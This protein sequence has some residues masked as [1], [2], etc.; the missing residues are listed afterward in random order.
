MDYFELND[1]RYE[2]PPKTL[3]IVKKEDLLLKSTSQEDAYKRQLD[4]CVTVLGTDKVQDLI[5]SDDLYKV[6]LIELTLLT[7]A[8]DRGYK[9]RIEEDSKND[10]NRIID[11]R[12]ADKIIK[13]VNAASTANSLTK[14]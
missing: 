9:K 2:L 1:N 6:D 5:G 12:T 4:L 3:E 13:M 8:I 7:N 10:I 11:D 14:R